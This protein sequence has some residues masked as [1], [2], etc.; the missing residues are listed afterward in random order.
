LLRVSISNTSVW[1]NWRLSTPTRGIPFLYMS[2]HSVRYILGTE[3]SH[4]QCML[5]FGLINEPL[6][7]NHLIHLEHQRYWIFSPWSRWSTVVQRCMLIPPWRLILPSLLQGVC[8]ALHWTLYVFYW[9]WSRLIH[10]ELQHSIFIYV[11][12]HLPLRSVTEFFF[13]FISCSLKKWNLYLLNILTIPGSPLA[14]Q[15]F[16]VPL[17]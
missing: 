11:F 5:I 10:F 15:L 6:A 7:S 8:V 13:F 16:V 3:N 1:E 12:F 9:L 14:A 4:L 17:Q 2:V